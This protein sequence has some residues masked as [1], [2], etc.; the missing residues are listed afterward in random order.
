MQLR[1]LN[2][3]GLIALEPTITMH[4]LYRAYAEW[5]VT[6]GDGIKDVWCVYE[7]PPANVSQM[8]STQRNEFISRGKLLT[9]NNSS[10]NVSSIQNKKIRRSPPSNCWEDLMRI[11]LF[12]WKGSLSLAK[13]LEWRNVVVLQ[14]YFCC[15]VEELHLRGLCCLRHLELIGLENLTDLALSNAVFEDGSWHKP[16]EG[17]SLTTLPEGITSV[18]KICLSECTRVTKQLE[19]LE[20]LMS[21]PEDIKT[22]ISS[23][24]TKVS[25]CLGLTNLPEKFE[26][27]KCWTPFS[28]L[29]L[30]ASE[31]LATLRL[32]DCGRLTR[33]PDMIATRGGV[34]WG[35]VSPGCPISLRIVGVWHM[36][37]FPLGQSIEG[38]VIRAPHEPKR[39]GDL[40]HAGLP[41]AVFYQGCVIGAPHEPNTRGNWAMHASPLG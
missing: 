26:T 30:R 9:K 3:T 37:A 34:S 20:I 14:L 18:A 16:I 4:D 32:C 13:I 31:N 33:L 19:N 36:S 8:H 2:R 24:T 6:R 41:I 35:T 12:G 27:W 15:D 38:H 39:K 29:L 11:Q 28:H 23:T 22:L 21:L 10:S 17:Q 1:H 5:Y 40:G 7:G 25:Q